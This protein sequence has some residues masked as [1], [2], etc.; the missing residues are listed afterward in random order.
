MKSGQLPLDACQPAAYILAGAFGH[1]GSLKA[2]AITCCFGRRKSA[3]QRDTLDQTFFAAFLFEE[4]CMPPNPPQDLTQLL[5]RWNE[6]STTALE[7]LAQAAQQ[8]LRKLARHYLRG[9]KAGHLLESVVLV[10]EAWMRL[11]DWQQISWQ[12]RAHF[13]GVAAKIMRQVLVDEARRRDRQKRGAGAFQVSLSGA[14]GEKVWRDEELI[15]LDEA[16][17]SLAALDQRKCRIIELR[18]F[19]GLSMEETAEVL[20]VSPRTV[21]RELRSAQ[22]WLY[23]EL[24]GK[25]TDDSKN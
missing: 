11:F 2:N 6:G 24:K 16:L 17:E 19:G 4:N 13:F 14:E 8:E 25:G 7:E 22:T 3:A 10:N 9:E 15:L 21:H 23:R 12:N 5:H 20:K 1:S 18:Y